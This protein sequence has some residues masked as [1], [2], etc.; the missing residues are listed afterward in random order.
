MKILCLCRGGNVRS[1]SLAWIL[2]YQFNH[3]AIACGIERNSPETIEMLAGWAERIFFVEPVLEENIPEKYR[4]KAT[5][6][7]TGPDIWGLAGHEDLMEHIWKVL[8]EAGLV[9][10]LKSESAEEKSSD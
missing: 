10:S 2:K 1:T 8:S 9:E 6:V 3:D 4:E 7:D 5:L